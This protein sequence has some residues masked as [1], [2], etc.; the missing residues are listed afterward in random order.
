[1]NAFPYNAGRAAVC[2]LLGISKFA[3]LNTKAIFPPPMMNALKGSA[4]EVGGVA[5]SAEKLLPTAAEGSALSLAESPWHQLQGMSKGR[6]AGDKQLFAAGVPE[7]SA[8]GQYAHVMGPSAGAAEVPGSKWV[9]SHLESQLTPKDMGALRSSGSG[10]LQGA[11]G[12]GATVRPP[13]KRPQLPPK[14]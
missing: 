9:R 14:P 2:A 13:R 6:S 8:T 10:V 1:M 11:E 12:A 4:K 3:A 7:M 5:H